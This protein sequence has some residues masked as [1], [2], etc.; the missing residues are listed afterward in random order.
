[1][2]FLSLNHLLV[3]KDPRNLQT[4]YLDGSQ[5]YGAT[6]EKAAQLRS[7]RKGKL[8]VNKG[9]YGL[10]M[11]NINLPDDPNPDKSECDT[12][13]PNND[14]RCLLSGDKRVNQH[15]GLTA[16]QAVKNKI[17]TMAV[18]VHLIQLDTYFYYVV[19]N[20]FCNSLLNICFVISIVV[21][22]AT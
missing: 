12:N 1:M 2:I 4:S 5:I 6:C 14:L 8:R 20:A 16:F 18:S 7:F 11:R 19:P 13:Y 10:Y 22:E 17:P 9:L 15:P 21:F 3:A